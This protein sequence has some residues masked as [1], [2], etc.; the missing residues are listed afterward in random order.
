ML[1]KYFGLKFRRDIIRKVLEN[2]LKTAGSISMQA[3]GAIAQSIGLTPQLAQVPAEAINRIKAPVMIKWQD[4]FAIIYSITE[5]ELVIATPEQGRIRRSPAAASSASRTK[6][7]V[8][9]L[10]VCAGADGTQDS[11]F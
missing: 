6:R 11:V 7:A 2:Q 3:C 8:Q 10:V 9:L 5:Q 4:S 1:S